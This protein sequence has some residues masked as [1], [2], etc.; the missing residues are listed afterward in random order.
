MIDT[1]IGIDEQ[2]LARIFDPFFTTKDYGTGLGLATVHGIVKQLGGHIQVQSK[3]NHGTTFTILLPRIE[4]PQ[5]DEVPDHQ[6]RPTN[7]SETILLVEDEKNVRELTREILTM[8]GYK[9]LPA[10]DADEALIIFPK[11]KGRD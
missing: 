4:E 5:L 11:A 7:G 1:G 8:S 2:T 3:L 9:V 10:P 6:E